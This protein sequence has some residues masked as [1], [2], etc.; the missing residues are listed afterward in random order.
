MGV[1]SSTEFNRY[2]SAK[3]NDVS[4]ILGKLESESININNGIMLYIAL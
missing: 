4:S 1:K 3:G 2:K